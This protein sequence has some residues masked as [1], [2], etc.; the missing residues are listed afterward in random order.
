MNG[1]TNT[2]DRRK[3]LNGAFPVFNLF[4]KTHFVKVDK[5][6]PI[7][8]KI[9]SLVMKDGNVVI[10]LNY[11]KYYN[12][13]NIFFTEENLMDYSKTDSFIELMDSQGISRKVYFLI[14]ANMFNR[15]FENAESIFTLK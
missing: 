14:L 6:P 15:A 12:M 13:A 5:F 11:N 10:E 1:K 2:S 7:L 9:N 3:Y 4:S 8:P